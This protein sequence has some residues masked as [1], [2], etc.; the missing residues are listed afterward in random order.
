MA[1]ITQGPSLSELP[2]DH[3]V[4]SAIK[5]REQLNAERDARKLRKTYHMDPVGGPNPNMHKGK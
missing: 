2:V 4:V 1:K 5:G 3:P